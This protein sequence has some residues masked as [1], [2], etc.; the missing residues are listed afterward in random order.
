MLHSGNGLVF[1]HRC[2]FGFAK[3]NSRE[4]QVDEIGRKRFWGR[5][6]SAAIRLFPLLDACPER[7]LIDVKLVS[8]NMTPEARAVSIPVHRVGN[9]RP[10]DPVP[11]QKLI[12]W[13]LT[14]GS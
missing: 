2:H 5:L 8:E 1:A 14:W 9:P 12:A 3:A 6:K 4:E 10:Q 11:L 7:R 13:C